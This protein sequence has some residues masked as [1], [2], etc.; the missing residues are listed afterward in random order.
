M[1]HALILS[2]S[3]ARFSFFTGVVDYLTSVKSNDFDIIAGVSGGAIVGAMVAQNK[4]IK[5]INFT[6]EIEQD[7]KSIHDSP[8][9][10]ENGHISFSKVI[11]HNF[12]KIPLLKMIG[13]LF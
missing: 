3:G 8:Y 11:S 13:S 7:Y 10:N 2:G 1:K 9:F 6:S 4:M 5:L 12:Q